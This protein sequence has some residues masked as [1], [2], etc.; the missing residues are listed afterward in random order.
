MQ[1]EKS[2]PEVIKQFARAVAALLDDALRNVPEGSRRALN[3]AT[4][5]GGSIQVTAGFPGRVSIDLVKP[6]TGELVVHIVSLENEETSE[7]LFN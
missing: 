4:E 2:N 5:R 3:A 1:K 7:H 6:G